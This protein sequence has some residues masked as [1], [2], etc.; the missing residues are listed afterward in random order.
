M[1]Q[2]GTGQGAVLIANTATIA[3]PSGSVSGREAQPANRLEFI[4]IFYAGLG[5]VTNSPPSGEPP[6]GEALSVT[7]ET[8]TVTIGG[9]EAPVS[10]SGLTGFVGLYQVNVQVPSNASTGDAVEV[11]LTIGGVPTNTVTIAVQ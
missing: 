11:V 7:T 9:V 2:E 1:K 3:A 8:P 5:D 4:S 6:S 10:F